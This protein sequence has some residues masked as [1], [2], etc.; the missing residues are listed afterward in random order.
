MAPAADDGGATGEAATDAVGEVPADAAVKAE[1]EGAAGAAEGEVALA[2][3]CG[4]MASIAAAVAADTRR[5]SRSLAAVRAAVVVERLGAGDRAMCACCAISRSSA[6]TTIFAA[7]RSAN[8]LVIAANAAIMGASAGPSDC[9]SGNMQ[10][11]PA[12]VW[13]RT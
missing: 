5:A 4:T 7:C 2:G 3:G 11:P 8:W 1:V 13:C 6:A 9:A 10:P 12:A